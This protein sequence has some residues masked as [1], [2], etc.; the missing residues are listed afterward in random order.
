MAER[1]FY[2]D[3]DID[4]TLKVRELGVSAGNFITHFDNVLQ[5]RTAAEVVADL[6][7][8]GLTDVNAT[9]ISNVIFTLSDASTLAESFSHVHTNYALIG[10]VEDNYASINHHTTHEIGGSDEVDIDGGGFV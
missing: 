1:K 10:W 7:I 6:G 5:E 9:N 4:G 3:V 2:T 8:A